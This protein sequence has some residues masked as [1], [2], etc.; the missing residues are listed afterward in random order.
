MQV[1]RLRGK[2]AIVT[3][4][5]SGIGESIATVFAREGAKVLVVGRSRDRGRQVVQHITN[6]GGE[7][8][9][10][11]VDLAQEEDIA[12]MVEAAV[13][14]WGRLDVLVNNAA[15]F[16]PSNFKPLADTSL[17]DWKYTVAVNLTAVFLACQ[18]AIPHMIKGGGG[19]IVNVSSIGGLNAFPTFAAYSITKGALMQLTQSVALDYAAV[20]IR[21]NAIAPGL[22]DT[23]GNEWCYDRYGGKAEYHGTLSKT[24]PLGRF[25]RS[26]EV[27]WVAVYLASDESAYTTGAIIVVDGGRTLGA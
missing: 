7:A 24:V 12:P 3:G 13:D 27:A 8:V 21:A 20:G 16:G 4:A 25:G 6:E 14:E 15:Y 23:P 5:T 2:V 11:P 1:M 18:A 26:D 22:V 17:D 9:F 19:S 10:R